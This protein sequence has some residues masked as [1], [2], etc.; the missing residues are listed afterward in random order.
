MEAC[1][2]AQSGNHQ[3]ALEY[4]ENSYRRREWGMAYLRID[5]TLDV[6]RVDPRFADI[7]RRVDENLP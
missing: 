1:M 4:L 5:P 6:L 2:A 3:K 7:L